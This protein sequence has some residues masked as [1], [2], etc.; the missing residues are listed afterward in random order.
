MYKNI[1]IHRIN[2]LIISSYLYFLHSPYYIYY[3]IMLMKALPIRILEVMPAFKL[4]NTQKDVSRPKPLYDN[5]CP[6]SLTCSQMT[7]IFFLV[8]ASSL[9]KAKVKK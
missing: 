7:I 1:Q 2:I 3:S 8:G 6:S 9:K 5:P 4:R